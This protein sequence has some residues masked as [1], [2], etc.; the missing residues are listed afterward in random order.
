MDALKAS[1]EAAI[2]LGLQRVLASVAPAKVQQQAALDIMSKHSVV[3][4]NVPGPAGRSFLAGKEIV[5]LRVAIANVNLQCSAVSYAGNLRLTVVADP[6]T[7]KLPA[8][9]CE[10]FVEELEEMAAAGRKKGE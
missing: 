4:T 5:D 10:L 8:R 6:G 3:F 9:L 1:P 2:T 7:V